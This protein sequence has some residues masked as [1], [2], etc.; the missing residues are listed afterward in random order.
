MFEVFEEKP[1]RLSRFKDAMTFLHTSPGLQ[2]SYVLNGFDWASLGNG[3]VVDVGG[4]HGLVSQEIAR[5]F[6]SLSFVVQDLPNVV[7]DA[8]TKVPADLA[9]RVTFMAHDMFSEQPVT[10]ADVYYFRWIL[11][12]W[13]D[14]Y[15]IKILR[16]LIPALKAGARIMFSERCLEAPNILG[17]HEEK[18]NRE[19]DIMM[20]ALCN[21]QERDHDDWEELLQAADARFKLEEVRRTAGAKLAMIVARWD[22]SA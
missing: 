19:W 4:S 3:L 17:S 21:A 20:L 6:P 10:D 5:E 15:C 7:E 18:V 12:S 22:E 1:E 9:G 14:K 8:K 2:K 11:H 13:S 16:S